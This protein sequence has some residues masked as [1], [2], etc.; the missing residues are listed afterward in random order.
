[1]VVWTAPDAQTLNW[2][3]GQ[4]GPTKPKKWMLEMGSIATLLGLEF[5]KRVDD[6]Q[7]EITEDGVAFVGKGVGALS[8]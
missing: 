3:S 8:A 5:I 7:F 1:M 4:D 2:F 6:E